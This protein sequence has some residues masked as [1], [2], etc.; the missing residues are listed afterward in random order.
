MTDL[1]K[2]YY[3]A[4]LEIDL[5][6]VVHNYHSINSCLSQGTRTLAVVKSDA[7]GHGAVPVARALVA[8]DVEMLGVVLV[9][10]GMELRRA[11]INKPI[12]VLGGITPE[13]VEGVVEHDLTQVVFSAQI[14]QALSQRAKSAGRQA[15]VHVKVDT[16]MG[17]L[18]L[19]PE[20]LAPFLDSLK[21]IDNI[22]VQG[23]LTHLAYADG[24]DPQY[25]AGQAELLRSL[26]VMA[27]EA[28]FKDLTCHCAASAA[29]VHYPEMNMDMVR[30]GIMLYGVPPVRGVGTHLDLKPAMRWKSRIVHLQEWEEGTSISYNRTYFTSR[31]SRIA[32]IP[33]GY[34]KG[35]SC[36]LANRG[37]M[38]VGG[39]K[40]PV[41][42]K[43]CMDM[44]MAD[45]TD[46][47]QVS[48]GD[49]VVVMGRQ[50]DQ[51]ITAL[52]IAEAFG[53]SPYEVLCMAGK[54]NPRLYEG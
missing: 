47:G 15:K 32:T 46:A 2:S 49:E 36:L 38:L 54:C 17:R 28:G 6:A 19:K 9:S 4:F 27:K 16:G 42:G 8:E 18:G 43:V 25:N 26:S 39:R 48:V 20:E 53:G 40:V 35:Y 29:A 44:S 3:P 13:Q 1:D 14:A 31:K 37:Q 22:Q 34:S 7:Y 11:G 5:Q 52:D 24:S 41:A 45:V 21:K 30:A 33:V 50:G 23:L 51:E 10:E 12:L